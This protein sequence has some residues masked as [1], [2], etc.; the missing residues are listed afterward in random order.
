MIFSSQWVPSHIPLFPLKKGYAKRSHTTLKLEI[1][2]TKSRRTERET[3]M[4]VSTLTVT[5]PKLH[6]LQTFNPKSFFTTKSS[7][8][9]PSCCSGSSRACFSNADNAKL[10]IASA[11]ATKKRVFDMGIGILA[12]SVLAMSPLD[13][14]ATRIEY[15]ATVGEP[16]C[17]LN[18]VKSG[19]G[20]CDVS[21][22]PGAQA[23][24]AELIDVSFNLNWVCF[25]FWCFYFF[26]NFLIF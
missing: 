18:F 14:D 23:P 26:V 24:Y 19:L 21:V 16:P 6:S 8:S 12:A 25:L 4:A 7:S 10:S 11:S 20:Y 2:Q 22:G 5:T 15:Y 9:S 3:K 17:E 13:A 1:A